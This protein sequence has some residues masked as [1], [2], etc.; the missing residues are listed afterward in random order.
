MDPDVNLSI[1]MP[2]IEAPQLMHNY[3]LLMSPTR[4]LLSAYSHPLATSC[5]PVIAA[6]KPD[7]LPLPDKLLKGETIVETL[8]ILLHLFI[9]EQE[10]Q[11]TMIRTIPESSIILMGKFLPVLINFQ[12]VVFLITYSAYVLNF[13]MFLAPVLCLV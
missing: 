6:P 13:T 5:I 7:Q 2:N 11:R 1:P 10:L 3:E 12:S 8:Q 4:T 9:Y